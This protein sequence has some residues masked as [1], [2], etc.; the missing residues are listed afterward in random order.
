MGKLDNTLIM[1][2]DAVKTF[3]APKRSQ[4]T[5]QKNRRRRGR[6]RRRCQIGEW[7]KPVYAGTAAESSLDPGKWPFEWS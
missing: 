7:V 1:Y 3:E 4:L 6:N 5:L 2:S